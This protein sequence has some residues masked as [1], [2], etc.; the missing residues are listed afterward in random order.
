MR[1]MKPILT[2]LLLVSA[3][4]ASAPVFMQRFSAE[5]AL[6]TGGALIGKSR[7]SLDLREGGELVYESESRAAGIARL[8]GDEHV[9]ERSEWRPI[10]GDLRPHSYLYR[11]TGRK[12]KEVRVSFDWERGL[13]H[14]SNKGKTSTI[15]VPAD[16]LDKLGYL[17][18]LMHD[19]AAGRRSFEYRVADGGPLRTY[20]LEA[21][22]EE[23]VRTP[24]GVFDTVRI[25]RIRSDG[26]RETTFWCA[27]SLR[28]LPVRVVH[29]ETDGSVVVLELEAMN[30]I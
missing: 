16:A 14:N 11:R 27:P 1:S 17:L 18:A 20:R 25:R 2:C 7:W 19:L 30:G 4:A 3:T 15:P 24:I 5:Y 6:T 13:A 12:D 23:A 8:L 28:F 26:E 10:D 29:K 9:I 22:D 21:V